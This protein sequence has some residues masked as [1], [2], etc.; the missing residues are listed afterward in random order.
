MN[1]VTTTSVFPPNY[2]ADVALE[3]LARVG[4]TTLDLAFDYCT[5]AEHPF[6]N[7]GWMEW[8]TTLRQKADAMG[9]RYTHAHAASCSHSSLDGVLRTFKACEILGIPY[10]VVHPVYKRGETMITNDEDF[11]SINAEGY[12]RM[13]DEAARHGVTVLTENLLWGSSIKTDVIAELVHRVNHPNFGWC[14]DTG[15]VHCSGAKVSDVRSASVVPLSLHIQDNHGA[16]SGDQ[17]LIPGDGTI[18]W[19]E[20]LDILKEIDY[21]GDLVLE[22]H[23]QSLDAPDEK[24]EEILATLLERAQ[25]MNAYLDSLH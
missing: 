15:H 19:K 20:F 25:K 3:R 12:E 1:I 7:D 10:L 23:H 8:A 6:M 16:G 21:Q 24:R 14:F 13:L 2:P 18:D 11:I 4:F 9:V 5:G 22:A 17:H